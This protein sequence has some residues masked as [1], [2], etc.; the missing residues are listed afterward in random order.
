M[1][2]Y[3]IVTL[4]NDVILQPATTTDT[5]RIVQI[6][7]NPGEMW[8]SALVAV[9]LQIEKVEILDGDSYFSDWTDQTV[10]DAVVAWAE[11][12]FTPGA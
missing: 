10:V 9:G 1:A 6:T 5:F 7:E 3:P 2:D 11:S 4:P 8:V 12:K